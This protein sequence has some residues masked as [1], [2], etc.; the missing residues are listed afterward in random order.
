M[1]K[2]MGKRQRTTYDANYYG[3]LDEEVFED[4]NSFPETEA[5]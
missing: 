4:F 5:E 3:H 2:G 1:E